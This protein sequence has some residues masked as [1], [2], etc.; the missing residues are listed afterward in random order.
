MGRIASLAMV[1]LLSLVPVDVARADLDLSEVLSNAGFE[2]DLDHSGWT[3]TLKNDNYSFDAAEVNPAIVPF[4]Q[5]DPLEAPAGLNFVGVLNPADDDING[6][7]VHEAVAGSF[8][9][10]TAFTVTVFASRGRLPAAGTAAFGSATAASEATLQ[11]F[12]W[13]AGGHPVVNP[14]TDDWSR[15]PKFTIRRVFSAWAANGEWGSQTFQFTVTAP[16]EYVSLAVTGKNHKA[17][18]YVAFDILVP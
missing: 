8:P 18:S 12:A 15:R 1:L 10:G 7:L 13:T 16:V 14:A 6:R 4:G 17:A 5:T 2:D 3:A 11:F 9:A